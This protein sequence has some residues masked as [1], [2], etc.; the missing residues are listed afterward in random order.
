M[1]SVSLTSTE[2]K[3]WPLVL[4]HHFD[5]LSTEFLPDNRLAS[6]QESPQP[7]LTS[8]GISQWV[9]TESP[10]RPQTVLSGHATQ[11][12]VFPSQSSLLLSNFLLFDYAVVNY[13]VFLMAP[14]ILT[15]F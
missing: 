13:Y 6:F 8:E 2:K 15:R 3:G 4:R 12:E 1:G 11:S 9:G 7:R 10:R 5:G 14:K